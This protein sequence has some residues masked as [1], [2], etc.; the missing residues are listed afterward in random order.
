MLR[1][2]STRVNCKRSQSVD[3]ILRVVLSQ[4][5]PTV[6]IQGKRLPENRARGVAPNEAG[7]NVEPVKHVCQVNPILRQR[8]VKG[9]AGVQAGGCLVFRFTVHGV[10]LVACCG[11]YRLPPHLA[12]VKPYTSMPSSCNVVISPSKSSFGPSSSAAT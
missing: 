3:E 4:E 8:A 7:P 10:P 6:L 1:L 12:G 9:D 2:Q 5:L 11:V